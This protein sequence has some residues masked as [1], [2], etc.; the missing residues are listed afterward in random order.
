MA[1][2]YLFGLVLSSSIGFKQEELVK[3]ITFN[4]CPVSKDIVAYEKINSNEFH[5]KH[6]DV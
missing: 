2:N 3:K 5:F 1:V 4:L 6:T